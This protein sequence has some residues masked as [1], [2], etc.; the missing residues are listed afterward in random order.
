MEAPGLEGQRRR[1]LARP[2]LTGLAQV[3]GRAGI[4]WSERIELDLDYVERWTLGRD[5]RILGRTAGVVLGRNGTYKGVGGGF[6][7]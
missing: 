5:L 1:L 4:P 3:N 2:G 6:D 7:L